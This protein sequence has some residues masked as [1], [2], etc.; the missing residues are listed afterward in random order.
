MDASCRQ[1]FSVKGRDVKFSDLVTR[2][3]LVM[4][5][6][7]LVG[8]GN[9]PQPFRDTPKVTTDNPL[10]DVPTAVGIAVLPVRG[11]PEPFGTQISS[12]VAARLQSFDIPAEAVPSNR[13]LGFTLEGE[14]RPSDA[15]V[16]DIPMV[17]TW[18]LKS[19]RGQGMRTY[20]QVITVPARSWREGDEVTATR[21]G[22]EVALQMGDLIGGIAIPAQGPLPTPEQIAKSTAPMPALPTVSVKPVEGAPGDGREALRLAVLQALN[23]NGVRRDDI[24]P[25]I[26]LTCHMISTPFDDNLQKVEIV[27]RAQDRTGKELGTVKL[28]NAIPVGAL[29][30]P[31]GPTA[32]AVANAAINDLLSLLAAHAPTA[33]APAAPQKP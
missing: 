13:G 19:R 20:R 14:A 9:L 16:S 10:L 6:L 21:L 28:D 8:C 26:N 7:V 24:N 1:L 3:F 22:N 11:A 25:D 27:W 5:A 18:T 32:F 17:V 2:A 12:A 29:D 23:D 30:G 15:A 33:G 31:W 4:T